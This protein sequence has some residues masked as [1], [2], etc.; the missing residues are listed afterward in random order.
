MNVFEDLVEELKGENLLEETVITTISNE[1]ARKDDA[2]RKAASQGA[3]LSNAAEK[4]AAQTPSLNNL[5]ANEA[6]VFPAVEAVEPVEAADFHYSE[7]DEGFAV[8]TEMLSNESANVFAAP[9][10]PV[11]EMEYYR[12]RAM[13]E[14]T[15]LQLVEH[16]FSGVE[17][18]QMKISPK[19]FDDIAVKKSLHDFLQ[20]S[21]DASASDNA[22]A[23]FKLMQETESWCSALSYRDKNLSVSDLRRYCETTK[24]VLSAQALLALAR[25]YRNLPHTEAV[26][27]K[28]EMVLT[29]LFTVEIENDQRDL[30]AS[31][32]EMIRKI[33]EHYAD[34][35]SVPLYSE[36]DD[37]ELLLITVKFDDFI[38]EAQ[39]AD[40][41]DEP[42]RND[43]YNRLRIFKESIGDKFYAP[44]VLASAIECS[45]YVGNRYVELLAAERE[46]SNAE[47]IQVKYGFLLDQSVSDAAGKTLLLS[48]L[49][50]EKKQAPA[51]E[52]FEGTKNETKT[53]SPVKKQS[54][55]RQA[56]AIGGFFGISKWV[57]GLLI[58]T[59]VL[60][61][62]LFVFVEFGSSAPVSPNV[63]KVNLDN[64]VFKD[65]LETAR[66]NQELLIGVV[67]ENWKNAGDKKKEEILGDLLN[68]G[69]DKG[70]KKVHLLNKDGATV[71][72]ASEAGIVVKKN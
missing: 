40:N 54:E 15:S 21:K 45:V 7:S 48:E 12:R 68:A 34:W 41:F 3:A 10:S 32:E 60:T 56:R 58:G 18:E 70:F 69:K 37:T 61:V 57:I 6:D 33:A 31:R 13:E 23:E 26:R 9:K 27:S 11:D 24:P 65:Y 29:R 66:I 55:K 50:A 42:V 30:T 62:G 51:A 1:E 35:A 4:T 67:S 14:V 43:F 19:P 64:S 25:F 49:L 47:A 44:M 63:Q 59:I 2:S 72:Y 5:T 53:V 16:V 39:S 28:F 36:T 8:D 46:Q 22:Q 20:V 38:A 52:S 71:G 17:R